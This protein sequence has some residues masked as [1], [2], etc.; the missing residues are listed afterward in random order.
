MFDEIINQDRVELVDELFD[1]D[2]QTLTLQGH[3]DREG[4][5]DEVRRWRTGFPD[6]H[7]DIADVVEQGDRIAWAVTA[8][9]THTG[10]FMGVPATG[11]AVRFD[12]LNIATMR[13][14]RGWRHQVVMDTLAFMVQIGVVSPAVPA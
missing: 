8:T 13:D 6:V 2:V 10:D 4:F 7:R 9:G 11:P 3:L 1:R 12:N 14:G 5:K